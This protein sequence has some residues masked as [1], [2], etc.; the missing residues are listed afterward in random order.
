MVS[1]RLP[2]EYT[3]FSVSHLR[4]RTKPNKTPPYRSTVDSHKAQRPPFRPMFRHWGYLDV[5]MNMGLELPPVDQTSHVD[6]WSRYMWAPDTGLSIWMP[7]F[8]M[9]GGILAMRVI[10]GCMVIDDYT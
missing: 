1:S 10:K 3:F 7:G 8:A 6:D 4:H 9:T 5:D 2:Y